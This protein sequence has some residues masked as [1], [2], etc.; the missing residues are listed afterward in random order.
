MQASLVRSAVVVLMILGGSGCGDLPVKKRDGSPDLRVLAD[1]GG[2]APLAATFD[3]AAAPLDT[4]AARDDGAD[5]GLADAPSVVDSG[6]DSGVDAGA[7]EV[8]VVPS[9]RIYAC[10]ELLAGSGNL[11]NSWRD[12]FTGLPYDNIPCGGENALGA[13]GINPAWGVIPQLANATLTAFSEDG[14]RTPA[15]VDWSFEDRDPENAAPSLMFALRIA[16]HLDD[17]GEA[18]AP[19]RFGGVTW[20]AN[21][22]VSRYDRLKVRYRTT[23]PTATWQ[24]KL[25]SGT[26]NP[27][28]PAVTLS[29]SS[30]WVDAEYVIASDFPR[31]DSRHLNYLT[32]A[33]AVTDGTMDPVLW[34]DQ[35]SFLADPARLADCSISCAE[36]LPP[37]PDLS[38]YEPQTG[39]VNV[40]NAVSYLAAAPAASLM[41]EGAAKDGVVRIL[42][43]LEAL[44]TAPKGAGADASPD[45]GAVPAAWFQDWHSPVSL[46]PSP[47]NH[48][49][50]LTDQPQL[51][52]ALMLA[53]TTW[54]DVSARAA[55]LRAKMD[56]S[57]LYDGSGGCP[58]TLAGGID[59]CAGVV[60]NWT[61]GYFGNDAMLGA[62]LAVA[63]GAAPACLWR[64][65][66]AAKGCALAGTGAAPWYGTGT[67]CANPAIPASDTGGP[68]LQ[69]AGLLY[70]TS[71]R[72]PMGA[73]SLRQSALNMVRSQYQFA[74]D[75]KLLLAGWASASDPDSCG[76]MSCG[77]LVPD[78]VTPYISG[79]AASDDFPETYR[80]LRAFHLLGVDAQLSTGD[81]EMSLGLR[82]AWNQSNA[83][84]ADR[85]LYLDTG[86]T[87]LGLLNA[88]GGDVI[89]QRFARHPVATAGYALLASGPPPCP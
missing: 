18:G 46:M 89:R 24:L 29:A 22:D 10:G 78:K 2:E 86:W 54:P 85:Y 12:P 49:A 82:D 72:I 17:G 58:G 13:T 25:N 41:D 81:H 42:G 74:A 64:D 28:E 37:F 20:G 27:V 84:A 56:F 50:S 71:D 15:T 59:R 3:V 77:E 33:A 35:I 76:Y 75:N 51:Y 38:C 30:S 39:V 67:T 14:G 47:R 73:L 65:G 21:A 1:T 62:F 60:P 11:L 87:V 79:M 52:A 53:E 26:V 43:S 34:I 70:L 9:D 4:A 88:C 6:V 31:T 44:P 61:V 40:A 8:T 19:N 66:L 23:S 69:L 83:S 5:A 80:M 16:L 57:V 68:F 55:A 36:P 48:V 63:S 45:G 32:L 7:A